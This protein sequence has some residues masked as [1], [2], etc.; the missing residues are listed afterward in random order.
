MSFFHKVQKLGNAKH[1]KYRNHGSV[2]NGMIIDTKDAICE[3]D[4]YEN[5]GLFLVFSMTRVLRNSK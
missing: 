1:T 2:V 4:L 3:N 5:F